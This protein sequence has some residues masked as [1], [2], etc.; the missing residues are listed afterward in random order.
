MQ[1]G[2]SECSVRADYLMADFTGCMPDALIREMRTE[3]ICGRLDVGCHQSWYHISLNVRVINLCNVYHPSVSCSNWAII[4]FEPAESCL[5][6]A[7]LGNKWVDADELQNMVT[8]FII[9]FLAPLHRR[10][11]GKRPC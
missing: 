7:L 1:T 11:R 4:A 8:C 9:T 2:K 3:H 10:R 5:E 6:L